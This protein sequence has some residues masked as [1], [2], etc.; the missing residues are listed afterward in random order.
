LQLLIMRSDA[1]PALRQAGLG[2]RESLKETDL[3]VH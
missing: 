1:G 2:A 3:G